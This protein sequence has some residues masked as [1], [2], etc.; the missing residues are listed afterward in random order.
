MKVP[1]KKTNPTPGVSG[2]TSSSLTHGGGQALDTATNLIHRL[3]TTVRLST[4]CSGSYIT[5]GE[6]LDTQ[7]LSYQTGEVPDALPPVTLT[8]LTDIQEADINEAT[9]CDL[10]TDIRYHA[11]IALTSNEQLIGTLNLIHNLNN[12]PLNDDT[13]TTLKTLAE[14]ISVTLEYAQLKTR[15]PQPQHIKEWQ[16]E[17]LEEAPFFVSTLDLSGNVLYMNQLL[18]NELGDYRGIEPLNVAD[19]LNA[20]SR[21]FLFKTVFKHAKRHGVWDGELSVKDRTGGQLPIRHRITAHFDADGKVTHYSS[22]AFDLRLEKQKELF[23]QQRS[24]VLELVSANV[25]VKTILTRLARLIEARCTGMLAS[26]LILKDNQLFLGAA[27]SLPSGYTRAIEGVTIGPTTGSCGTAAYFKHPITVVDIANDPLWEDYAAVALAHGLYACWS[28]PIMNKAGDVLGTFALYYKEPRAPTNDEL[29]LLDEVTQLAAIALSRHHLLAQL[30]HQAYHDA[31]TGLPN[32]LLMKDRLEQA[33]WQADRANEQVAVMLLDLDDFKTINDSLGHNVGDELLKEVSNILRA[34]ATSGDTIARLGGDE[35]ALIVPVTGPDDCARVA[36][37]IQEKLSHPINLK[38]RQHYLTTSIG[39]SI[40]PDDGLI[41]ESLL[42]AADSAMYAAKASGKR[43]YYFYQQTM[44]EQLEKHLTL[45]NDLREALQTNAFTL[46]YQS[47]VEPST[48]TTR[49]Y[50]ALIRWQHPQQGLLNPGAFLNTAEKAG[51]MPDIDLWV[52]KHAFAQ[53]ESWQEQGKPY[54]LSCNLSAA[55]FKN[56][57]FMQL[58]ISLF[59]QTSV[60][61]E[62]LELEIT[63]NV[64][65]HNI[66]EAGMLLRQLKQR[67]PGICVSIDDFGSG[68]SSLSYLRHLPIDVL[69]IDRAF[70]RDLDSADM[71]LKHTALAVIRTVIALGHDLHFRVVAEGAETSVQYQMLTALGVDEV[72]GYYCSKP[73]PLSNLD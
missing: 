42:R 33:L 41:P 58:L 73:Q 55:S 45:E 31:L 9:Y 68:Y 6:T 57:D 70:V 8:N 43:S 32:R 18:R 61:P 11:S 71:K 17:L 22:I 49:G 47:R 4:Q 64:L 67:L 20:D 48:S 35:F 2:Q 39:I 7:T 66:D 72:Q 62:K 50:E 3:L 13:K 29:S 23:Q 1:V 16:L 69:K 15:V 59:E 53:L 54:A 28:Q 38:D 12:H 14:S 60:S 5:L 56:K 46:Y 40:Y 51:L 44:T 19:L 65:M 25:D 63:E 10:N 24:E 34:C 27:P 52:L 30:E 26:I 21:D 37:K 36:S